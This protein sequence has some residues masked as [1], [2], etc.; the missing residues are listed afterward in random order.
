MHVCLMFCFTSNRSSLES[1]S[2][3]YNVHT[4][5]KAQDVSAVQ[6]YIAALHRPITWNQLLENIAVVGPHKC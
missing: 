2:V 1:G 3:I 5:R 4:I 6:V